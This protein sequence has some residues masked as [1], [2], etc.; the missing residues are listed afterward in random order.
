LADKRLYDAQPE[1]VFA[2]LIHALA[3]VSARVERVE[4]FGTEVM[5]SASGPGDGEFRPFSAQ[6]L[7]AT[8]GAV[9]QVHPLDGGGAGTPIRLDL[10]LIPGLFD[11]VQDRLDRGPQAR[12]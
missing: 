12:S 9:V 6:V 2:A 1:R 7:P 11:A 4:G 3:G 8:A 10:E 5:F